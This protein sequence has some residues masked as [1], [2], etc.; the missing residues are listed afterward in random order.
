MTQAVQQINLTS[1]GMDVRTMAGIMAEYS[2]ED[3]HTHGHHQILRI[4]S[5][6]AMLVD[7]YCKQPMFGALTAFVPAGL[8]H[9]SVVLGQP[10]GYKSVYLNKDFLPIVKQKIRLFFIS[11]LGSALFDR[12]QIW[13]AAGSFPEFQPGVPGSIPKNIA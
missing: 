9:R 11:P 10:V 13:G 4:R 5:G 12:M 7:E 8:A 2:T 3:L 1:H 6:V